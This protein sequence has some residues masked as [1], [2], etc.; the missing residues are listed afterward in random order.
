M[1]SKRPLASDLAAPEDGRT[2]VPIPSALPESN[3]EMR[4]DVPHATVDT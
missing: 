2:P 1:K 4:P 3:Y